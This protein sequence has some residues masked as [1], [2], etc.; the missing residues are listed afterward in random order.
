[1][2]IIPV[3]NPDGVAYIERNEKGDGHIELKRKNGRIDEDSWWCPEVLQGVDLNRNYD[4]SWDEIQDSKPCSETY[5][6]SE[7]FS[8]PETRTMRNFILEKQDTL[9]FILNYHSYGNML[10]YPYSGSD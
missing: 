4:V 3:V 6:G 2:Y 7:P 10:I 5:H 8:E 1:M 9:K